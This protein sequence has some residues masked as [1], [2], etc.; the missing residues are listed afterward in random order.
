[1]WCLK[2]SGGVLGGQCVT[3]LLAF[4]LTD[5]NKVLHHKVVTTSK[6]LHKVVTTNHNNQCTYNNHH[7]KRAVDAVLHS[8][9]AVPHLSVVVVL[10][11]VL[12]LLVS[13]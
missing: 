6:V 2:T 3:Y 4:S 10:K 12:M 8:V 9:D 7:H 13:L 11:N 5:I 1:M